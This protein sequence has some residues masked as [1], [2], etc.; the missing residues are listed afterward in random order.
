VAAVGA[1]FDHSHGQPA[2]PNS[3]E[4]KIQQRA[5]NPPPLK[6]GIH[7]KDVDLSHRI[8]L[9]GS[10]PHEAGKL[11]AQERNPNLGVFIVADSRD[12][13]SLPDF[14]TAW[15]ESAVHKGRDVRLH[16]RKDRPSGA[17]RQFKQSVELLGLKG[18][19]TECVLAHSE[20][21]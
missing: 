21:W 2:A 19:D 4:R 17:N 12:V 20:T 15:I 13:S 6:R 8:L 5:P 1:G 7:G 18:T 14:P 9:V 3:F 16:Q 11:I 10:K